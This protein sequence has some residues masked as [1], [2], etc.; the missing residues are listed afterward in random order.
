MSKPPA[1]DLGANRIIN[2][3]ARTASQGRPSTYFAWQITLPS[4]ATRT[5]DLPL[6]TAGFLEVRGL[7]IQAA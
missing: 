2:R 6:S 1:T 4:G 5:L 7:T 3:V